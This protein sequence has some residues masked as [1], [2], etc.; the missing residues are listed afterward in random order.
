MALDDMVPIRKVFQNIHLDID[1]LLIYQLSDTHL[2]SYMHMLEQDLDRHQDKSQEI[3]AYH[4]NSLI[5]V[6]YR[7]S[8]NDTSS[9]L[10]KPCLMHSD[11]M[12]SHHSIL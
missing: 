8:N 11:Y 5:Q 1:M 9:R 12:V 7:K 2:H 4:Y 6:F 10:W 3:P